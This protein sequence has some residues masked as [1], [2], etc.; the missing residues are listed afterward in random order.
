M[1][2]RFTVPG[3][4]TRARVAPGLFGVAGDVL[5]RHEEHP[6]P[7]LLALRDEVDWFNHWLP[8]PSR[9][10]VVAK[11]RKWSDGVCWFRDDAR[12]MVG[13]AYVL[14][15]LLE[16]CGVPIERI[17]TRDPGQVL[18]RDRW[19]VVAKPERAMLH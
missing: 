18:Y 12:E 15:A 9:F 19:Q 6:D 11:G 1:Y 2:L 7:V 3:T 13:H 16:E 17:W 8:I 5:W 10:G 4:V 14:A